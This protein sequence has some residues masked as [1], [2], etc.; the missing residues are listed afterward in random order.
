MADEIEESALLAAAA[1]AGETL[2]SHQLKRWRRAGLI[3]RPRVIHAAGVR[4]SSAWYPTW[5][6]EQLLAVARVHRSVHKLEDLLMALW[7]E[8]HWVESE[9]LRRALIAP[10]ERLSDETRVARG[11][12]EDPYEAADAIMAGMP[13][14]GA[15]PA[16]AALMRKRLSGRADFLDLLWTFLVLGLGGQAP[17][18]QE[19]LSLPDPA[20]GALQL[21][22]TATG[23]ERAMSDDPAGHGPWLPSD[24]DLR[25]FIAEMRDAGGFELEDIA[26]PV[27]QASPQELAQA[28]EDALLLSGLLAMIGRVLEGLLG[29]DIAGLGFLSALTSMTAFARAGL[30]RTVLIL[31]PL[32]G[33]GAFSAI[34]QL[35]ES[36]Q[37][38][39]AAIAELR[40]ALPQHEA[41]LKVDYAERLAALPLGEAEGVRADVARVLR[42]HPRLASALGG[43]TTQP[44]ASGAASC[45]KAL[46]GS[47]S[48]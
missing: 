18:E 41:L 40:A 3:P 6:V 13:D 5:T 14:D 33:A 29:E 28:R 19:D 11:G 38:R 44:G 25:G 8:G 17:W 26:R 24:F 34:A 46:A 23:V 10:L 21:L 20:P 32:A 27:R 31:R 7:W 9:A 43:E 4:G 22:A 45:E 36:V 35:V 30:V 37:V 42:E 12:V 1:R 16:A 2:S 39:F 47:G 15:P 48:A